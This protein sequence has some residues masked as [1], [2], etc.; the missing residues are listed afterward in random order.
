MN[1]QQLLQ[2]KQQR[3]QTT[4]LMI[5][6]ALLIVC[7]LYLTMGSV[8]INPFHP[9][10]PLTS[11]LLWE[12]R[13]PRLLCALLVGSALG[14]AGA[15]LQILLNNSLAEPGVIGISGG[16]SVGMLIAF[17][18]FPAVLMT[19]ALILCAMAGAL[20]FTLLLVILGQ[21]L[22]LT[23]AKLLLVGVALGIVASAVV[24]WTFYFS[25]TMNLRQLIYWLM[26]SF[27]G[28]TWPQNALGLLLFTVII[29]LVSKGHI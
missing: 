4:T 7:V 26:G 24:T 27:S 1:F 16:A 25:N 9:S 21:T 23:T 17:F 6:I 14:V 15:T 19:P 8:S 29:L 2:R 18:F 22:R 28:V 5:S 20:G 3:W 12:L 10:S 13:L 11:R